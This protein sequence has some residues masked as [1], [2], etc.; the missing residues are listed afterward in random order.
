L[1][2]DTGMRPVF[3]GPLK[4]AGYL[5]HIAGLWIDLTLNARVDGAFGFNL[6]KAA[7]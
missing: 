6:V 3:V 4:N 1:I 5:E 7:L 2:A